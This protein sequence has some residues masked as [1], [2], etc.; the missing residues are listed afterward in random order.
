LNSDSDSETSLPSKR[1]KSVESSNDCVKKKDSKDNSVWKLDRLKDTLKMSPDKPNK[2][3]P[4]SSVAPSPSEEIATKNSSKSNRESDVSTRT[5]SGSDVESVKSKKE[6]VEGKIVN[7]KEKKGEHNESAELSHLMKEPVKSEDSVE[8][9][10]NK[11]LDEVTPALDKSSKTVVSNKEL[12]NKIKTEPESKMNKFTTASSAKSDI[13]KSVV[14]I[15]GERKKNE[16]DHKSGGFVI[17]KVVK[18]SDMKVECSSESPLSALDSRRK[19]AEEQKRKTVLPKSVGDLHKHAKFGPTRL[20]NAPK[21]VQVFTGADGQNR[22]QRQLVKGPVKACDTSSLSVLDMIEKH[23]GYISKPKQ[24]SSAEQSVSNRVGAGA[25]S[26]VQEQWIPLATGAPIP[27]LLG[28]RDLNSRQNK[29]FNQ[30]NATAGGPITN[31]LAIGSDKRPEADERLV[32]GGSNNGVFIPDQRLFTGVSSDLSTSLSSLGTP[33]GLMGNEISAVPLDVSSRYNATS[34]SAA[35]DQSTL[36]LSFD[37]SPELSDTSS[38]HLTYRTPA[39]GVIPAESSTPFSSMKMNN[40]LTNYAPPTR[41]PPV[42]LV[43]P[44]PGYPNM[45]GMPPLPIGVTAVFPNMYSAMSM[46]P[47]PMIVSAEGYSTTYPSPVIPPAVVQGNVYQPGGILHPQPPQVTQQSSMCPPVSLMTPATL[48]SE[49]S[50]PQLRKAPLLPTPVN[51]PPSPIT[52]QHT[53]P[54]VSAQPLL[55]IPDKHRQ[56]MP[57]QQGTKVKF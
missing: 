57:H 6:I 15:D 50:G 34:T 46:P 38:P 31:I 42:P 14:S 39:L 22:S 52:G 56:E 13:K 54:A 28:R 40:C 20:D 24:K 32:K 44:P 4:N 11:K 7:S 41:F 26:S 12:K 17:P 10:N 37:D 51:Q 35:T 27:T 55:P 21:S 48:S 33:S 16:K 36:S 9:V 53:S 45:L 2:M 49:D 3:A 47:P 30:S 23:P 19:V 25:K 5:I 8:M 18:R 1:S 29:S 43:G